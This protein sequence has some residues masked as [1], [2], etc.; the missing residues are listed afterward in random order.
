[1][2]TSKPVRCSL[3]HFAWCLHQ[4]KMRGRCRIDTLCSHDFFS[5]NFRNLILHQSES[6][7]SHRSRQHTRN[8]TYT[9]E[10]IFRHVNRES[11][12]YA[13]DRLDH[14]L[15]WNIILKSHFSQKRRL[16]VR[17]NVDSKVTRRA[18]CHHPPDPLKIVDP[19]IQREH[20]RSQCW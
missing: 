17:S 10:L 7:R 20:M 2:A 8:A 6:D 11:F 13:I 9:I 4:F 3:Q 1:M 5:R 18:H 12:T 16:C 15:S 19:E 14:S